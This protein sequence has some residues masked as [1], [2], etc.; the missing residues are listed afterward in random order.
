MCARLRAY[1]YVRVCVCVCARA[2][3]RESWRVHVPARA[4]VYFFLSS[5]QLVC[6]ISLRLLW[7]LAPPYFSKL[8]HKG[9]IFRKSYKEVNINCYECILYFFLSYW[10]TK[11]IFSTQHYTV[12][13][14]LFNCTISS[15]LLHSDTILEKKK[16]VIILNIKYV[17][18]SSTNFSVTVPILGTIQK[19][20]IIKIRKS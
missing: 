13:C 10:E 19:D 9:T 8:S 3:D 7:P 17:L 14:G 6:A 1:V 16:K 11:R 18:I 4:C 15:T 2:R 5:M 20:V 12:M